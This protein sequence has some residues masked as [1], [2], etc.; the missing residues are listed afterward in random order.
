M[1]CLLLLNH[2]DVRCITTYYYTMK[3]V[4]LPHFCNHPMSRSQIR[5]KVISTTTTTDGEEDGEEDG[6]SASICGEEDGYSGPYSDTNFC[7]TFLKGNGNASDSA[8]NAF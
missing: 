5:N 8:V 6:G 2:S 3:E 7:S 4:T 1:V